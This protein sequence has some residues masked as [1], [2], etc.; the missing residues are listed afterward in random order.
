MLHSK[1]LAALVPFSI[2]Q[3]KFQFF[4][5]I[6][7]IIMNLQVALKV[8]LKTDF[9]IMW[10]QR[11]WLLL[12]FLVPKYLI[13]FCSEISA[14]AFK[15]CKSNGLSIFDWKQ[16]KNDSMR[17]RISNRFRII[18]F[19]FQPIFAIVYNWYFQFENDIHWIEFW[20]SVVHYFQD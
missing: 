12:N 4:E 10:H 11:L 15:M 1:R 18:G 2:N 6:N 9:R 13:L 14:T 17:C 20:C 7:F 5:R 8:F 16:T 3:D 19:L